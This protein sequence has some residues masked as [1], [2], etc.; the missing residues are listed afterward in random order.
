MYYYNHLYL[1]DRH[2]QFISTSTSPKVP[3]VQPTPSSWVQ[4]K[5]M[6]WEIFKGHFHLSPPTF[7]RFIPETLFK[8]SLE[9]TQSM[10]LLGLPLVAQGIWGIC[11]PRQER[12]V[13]SP[14]QKIPHAWEQLKPLRR[15]DWA[16][17]LEPGNR[18]TIEALRTLCSLDPVLSNRR[19][20]GN[21]EE[22]GT[23]QP[24][25]SP[26]PQN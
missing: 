8:S 10:L 26:A 6:R 4:G 21:E 14:I 1:D 13:P 23:R 22:P 2:P 3:L 20:Q 24:E 15:N 16:W 25:R 18:P 5:K 12:W 19:S 9:T 17:T 11:L 7:L